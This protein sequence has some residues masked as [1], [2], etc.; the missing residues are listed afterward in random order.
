MPASGPG[1]VSLTASPFRIYNK[2]G[3]R[4]FHPA[5]PAANLQQN[6]SSKLRQ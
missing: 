6:R 4:T 1:L 2:N 3:H 5:V